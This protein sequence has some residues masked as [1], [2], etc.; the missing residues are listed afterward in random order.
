MTS[1]AAKLGSWRPLLRVSS[2]AWLGEH[3]GDEGAL[4]VGSDLV[5][6]RP[7]DPDLPVG[8]LP[9]LERPYGDVQDELTRTPGCGAA[10][11]AALSRVVP[12]GVIEAAFHLGS[13]HWL[14]GACAWVEHLGPSEQTRGWARRLETTT[15]AG[16]STRH[17]AHRL[18]GHWSVDQEA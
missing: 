1:T 12:A 8:C 4:W 13:A 14:A 16:Q 5:A 9:L 10:T 3:D 7:I 2:A 11:R 15:A 18:R 17:R 6:R